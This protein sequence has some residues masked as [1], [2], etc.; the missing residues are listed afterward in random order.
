MVTLLFLLKK[1]NNNSSSDSHAVNNKI[2]CYL[3]ILILITGI[4]NI[5]LKLLYELSLATCDLVNWC[6]SRNKIKTQLCYTMY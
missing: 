1:E 2:C 5:S 6:L 3:F 4:Y